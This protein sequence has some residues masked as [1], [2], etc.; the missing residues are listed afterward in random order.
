MELLG[1][2]HLS[3][4]IHGLPLAWWMYSA[5]WLAFQVACACTPSLCSPHCV[6]LPL[7]VPMLHPLDQTGIRNNSSQCLTVRNLTGSRAGLWSMK[8]GPQRF[9]SSTKLCLLRI[10][11]QRH[12]QLVPKCPSTGAHGDTDSCFAAWK[13]PHPSHWLHYAQ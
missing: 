7:T 6:P 4:D 11:N 5:G 13:F 10:P 3:I 12:H 9:T 2:R 1:R 8:T